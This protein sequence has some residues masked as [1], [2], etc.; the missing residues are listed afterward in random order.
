VVVPGWSD[1]P[2]DPTYLLI[3]G[4]SGAKK[5]MGGRGSG[6]RPSFGFNTDKCHE[7]HSVDLAWLR[8]KNLLILGRAS[9]INWSRGGHQTGSIRVE[10]MGHGLRLIYKRRAQNDEWLDVNEIVPLSETSANFGGT[11]QWFQC[12]S[13]RNRCRIIYGGAYFRCRKCYK[14]KYETQYEPPYGRAA[15]RA[16]KIR[17]RLG[18]REGFAAPF[19]EKPKGMHWATYARLSDL[20][21]RLQQFWAGG[22]TSWLRKR[23]ADE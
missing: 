21:E 15:S 20:D 7:F 22:I 1:R 12:L 11:R 3:S 9:S 19:P 18:C 23:D 4:I 8:R 2:Q 13:C 5:K 17:E 6:R 10:Y 14:L 16:V